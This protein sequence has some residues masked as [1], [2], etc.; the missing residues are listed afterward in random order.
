[1]SSFNVLQVWPENAYSCPFW[2]V[3]GGFD[4]LDGTQYQ[5]ISQRLNLRVIAVLAVY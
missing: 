1:M 3:F 4:P 2:V 5:P